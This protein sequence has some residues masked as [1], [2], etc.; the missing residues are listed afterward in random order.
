MNHGSRLPLALASLLLGCSPGVPTSVLLT[1]TAAE[2]VPDTVQV[3][4][5]ESG[6]P[7]PTFSTFPIPAAGADGR[8]G[9][10]VIYA[11]EGPLRVQAQGLRQGKVISEGTTRVALTAGRQT[12]ATLALAAPSA[13]GDGDGVPDDIDDCPT[14]P[15]PGQEDGDRDGRGDAC[16]P[17]DAGR[18]DGPGMPDDVHVTTAPDGGPE[19][20]VP[21]KTAGAA[22]AIAAECGSGFCTDGVCCEAA[23]GGPCQS[24]NL[25]GSA[26]ACHDVPADGDPRPGGCAPEPIE[27]CGR[28]G[29][30]D[31]QGQ[32][33]RQPAGAMCAPARCTDAAEVAPSTCKG[34]AC[35]AGRSRTCPSSFGCK[36][37]ACATACSGDQECAQASYCVAPACKPRHEDGTACTRAS[38][39]SSGWCTDAHCCPVPQCAPGTYCGGPGGLCINKK[40]PGDPSPCSADYECVSGD[41]KGTCQ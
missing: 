15:N 16:S 1:I 38:E 22:C 12:A 10:V 2:P 14:V 41:C 35:V 6:G 24:C 19:A 28:T 36:G 31:G 20:S 32:C 5:F 27:T 25:P 9:T 11:G 7:A 18:S 33:Q 30:C 39:C 26:G 37:D 3:R 23:C 4:A 29:K 13:D 40:F 34:G 17:A 21:P 8:L